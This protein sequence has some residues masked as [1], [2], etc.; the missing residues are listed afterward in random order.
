MHVS[1]ILQCY[2][3]ESVAA[4]SALDTLEEFEDIFQ[5]P[6]SLPPSRGIHDHRIPLQPN[7][8]TNI[9]PYRY[10]LKQKD[11]IKQLVN[12]MLENR[13]IQPSCS[14]FASAVVLIGK[15]DGSWR[16]CVDY[17]ELNKQTIKDKFPIPIVEELIDELAEAE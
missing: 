11:I 1:D 8:G 5:E 13:V 3:T 10:P 2:Q 14:S 7:A 16:M 4:N 12:E 15:K 6:T 17:R 9:R